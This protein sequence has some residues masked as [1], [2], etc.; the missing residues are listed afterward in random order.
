V[1]I[2]EF[3]ARREQSFWHS[4]LDMVPVWDDLITELNGRSGA[5]ALT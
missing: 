4:L 5:L 1:S 3:Q 2:E